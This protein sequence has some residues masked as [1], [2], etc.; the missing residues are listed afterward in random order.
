MKTTLSVDRR[1]CDR[2]PLRPFS[3]VLAGLFRRQY[4]HSEYCRS[5]IQTER[6]RDL[7]AD[8]WQTAQILDDCADIGLRQPGIGAPWHDGREDAAVRPNARSNGGRDLVL[9]P[10]AK[11]RALVGR[12]IRRNEH[13]EAGNLQAHVG[14]SQEPGH[15]RLPEKMTGRVAVGAPAEL[16]E[17]FSVGYLRAL[18]AAASRNRVASRDGQRGQGN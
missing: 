18:R 9:A 12:E 10:I 16:H 2:E 15:V 17:V 8:R 13:A 3:I 7:V 14:T 11:S 4:R 6:T 1:P 5:L